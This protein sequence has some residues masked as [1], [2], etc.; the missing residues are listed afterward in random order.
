MAWLGV[1]TAREEGVAVAAQTKGFL[2]LQS[3]EF[4]EI[5]EDWAGP[6]PF[7]R[8]QSSYLPPY[9]RAPRNEDLALSLCSG[10]KEDPH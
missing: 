3:S 10:E 1:E 2:Y 6:S 5:S 4:F 8:L 9:E 7:W